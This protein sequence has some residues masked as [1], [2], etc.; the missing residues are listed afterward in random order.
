[1]RWVGDNDVGF[2]YRIHHSLIGHLS[3]Q[4]FKLTFDLWSPLT[5]F[6]LVLHFLSSHHELIFVLPELIRDIDQRHQYQ[7]GAKSYKRPH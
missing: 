3:L 2:G 6:Q 1:M 4:T 5:I 7:H